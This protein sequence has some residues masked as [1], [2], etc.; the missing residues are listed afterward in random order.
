MFPKLSKKK[1]IILDLLRAGREMYG[2]ELVKESGGT[3]PRG[4]VYVTLDRMEDEGLV[5]SQ[6]E[7]DPNRS[8]SP[9][10]LFRITGHG[11]RVLQAIDAAEAIMGGLAN[12]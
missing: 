10:R 11:S 2:L 5:T 3:L 12:G 1:Y 4:T 7:V 8:G 9:R 6:P